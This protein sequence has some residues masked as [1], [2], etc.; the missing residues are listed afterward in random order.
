MAFARRRIVT[1]L[2]TANAIRPLRGNLGPLGFVLGWPT[3]ELAP[4]LLA[5]T[6]ADT[7]QAVVRGKAS[8][9]R[10]LLAAASAAGIGYLIDQS[11]NAAG[12][13][14]RALSESLG[15]NYLDELDRPRD[16]DLRT[17]LRDLARPFSMMKPGVEV[18]RDINYRDGGSRARL[19]IY[20]PEGVD[21]SNA[22]VLIQVHGGGWTIGDKSQQGLLLMNR[23]A[24]RGWI[25]V[26]INYR[27]APKNP[28][29]AQ[30]IDVKRAIAWTRENIASYGGDPSYLVLTG[31]SAGG[32]LSSLAA[33]TP[34]VTEYQPGF[35]DADTSVSACVSFYGVYDLAGIIGDQGSVGLRDKFLARRVFKLD[36]ATELE[37]FTLSSPLAQ[38]TQDAPDFFVIHGTND[39]LVPVN[40][41]HAFVAA[42]RQRS[43]G[44]VTYLELPNAQ[45]AFEVF[46]SIR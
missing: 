32:H 26:A 2:L 39:G 45:H 30:I 37:Q 18:I 41:A 15:A 14:E 8:K 43:P 9:S 24:A 13:A 4:Q 17:P 12:Q 35:E 29:P 6:V 36:P 19:D 5:L 25:C 21:L 44:I 7:A 3:T 1:A 23:M 38:V 34:S 31:G 40:Q 11:R 22:P 28:F 16:A 10:L 33:V 42:L 27:L 46:S 20:R